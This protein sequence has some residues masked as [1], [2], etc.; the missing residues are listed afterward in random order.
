MDSTTLFNPR[1]KVRDYPDF[2][3]KGGKPTYASENILGVLFRMCSMYSDTCHVN[4]AMLDTA[5]AELNWTGSDIE[6]MK[7]FL[8]AARKYR[9]EYHQ[10]LKGLMDMYGI[11]T[12][13]ELVTGLAEKFDDTVI[14]QGYDVC[15]DLIAIQ[16]KM[17]A[18]FRDLFL[19]VRN[20]EH[21]HSKALIADRMKACQ[22]E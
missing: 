19:Q 20:D 15:R 12:E 21:V 8:P 10:K 4:Q 6:E 1:F 22:A 17:R 7:E 2:M 14:G 18:E 16:S 11:R 5:A 13:A 9:R 3:R